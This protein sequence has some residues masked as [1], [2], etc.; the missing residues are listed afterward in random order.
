MGGRWFTRKSQWTT[1]RKSSKKTHL[2]ELLLG[3]CATLSRI[4]SSSKCKYYK[5]AGFTTKAQATTVFLRQICRWV[6]MRQAPTSTL[7]TRW[8]M[9]WARS[10]ARW[11]L[12]RSTVIVHPTIVQGRC[13][14]PRLPIFIRKSLSMTSSGIKDWKEQPRTWVRSKMRETLTQAILMGKNF[15][16]HQ[17][18]ASWQLHRQ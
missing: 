2:G 10:M 6:D 11:S 3:Q 5:R 4:W 14:C 15:Q 7:I 16:I 9:E 1:K 18:T 8:A 17:G 12:V 13:T